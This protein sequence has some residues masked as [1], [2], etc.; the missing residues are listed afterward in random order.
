ML[1]L[2]PVSGFESDQ[3]KLAMTVAWELYRVE[4]IDSVLCLPVSIGVMGIIQDAIDHG[5]DVALTTARKKWR[6]SD[7]WWVK[8]HPNTEAAKKA[9]H[10]LKT[11]N[12]LTWQEEAGMFRKGEK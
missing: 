6:E 1:P 10:N 7:K 5:V 9:R 12:Y 4:H 2:V 3:H 11:N 8:Y